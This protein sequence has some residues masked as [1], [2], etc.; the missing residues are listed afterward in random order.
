[1]ALSGVTNPGAM[2]FDPAGA[3]VYAQT[4]S[5]NNIISSY[6][7]SASGT[8]TSVGSVPGPAQIL[9]LSV[10]P[11]GNVLYALDASDHLIAAYS[12]SQGVLTPLPSSP[13]GLPSS[14]APTAFAIDPSESYLYV[15]EAGADS[16]S[17][18]T[19]APDG[20]LTGMSGPFFAVGQGPSCI[21]VD[22]GRSPSTSAIR[23]RVTFG[24][25]RL[26]AT[27]GY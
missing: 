19:I 4:G 12:I 3:Y 25:T 18:F 22:A 5:N 24:S 10:S 21:E 11:S 27:T 8:L 9:Q 15:T 1:V 14:G 6:S 7:V 17:G 2:A 20:S 26:P 13:F 23:T 16:L